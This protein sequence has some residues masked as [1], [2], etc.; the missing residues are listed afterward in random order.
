MN[1]LVVLLFLVG[2]VKVFGQTTEAPESALSEKHKHR[3]H[4]L[5]KADIEQIKEVVEKNQTKAEHKAEI[6]A[7]VKPLNQ[8][9]QKHAK[10]VN[11]NFE[12]VEKLEQKLSAEDKA[13]FQKNKALKQQ[14]H[15]TLKSLPEKDREVEHVIRE[16]H[17][18]HQEKEEREGY[19]K[20]EYKHRSTSASEGTT[21]VSESTPA[22]GKIKI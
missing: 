9:E 14:E 1:K 2:L 5:G 20:K 21:Q 19:H 22:S 11:K 8:T 3:R 4:R 15:E 18:R 12:E 10:E 7:F 13:A 16:A 6:D 17:Q